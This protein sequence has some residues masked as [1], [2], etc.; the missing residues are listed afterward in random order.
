MPAFSRLKKL[1]LTEN[2]KFLAETQLGLPLWKGISENEISL[3][4]SLLSDF[5]SD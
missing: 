3:I 4:S 5:Y 1:H 2:A